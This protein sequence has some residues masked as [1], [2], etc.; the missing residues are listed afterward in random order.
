M[1]GL[2]ILGGR[3]RPETL[4]EY[5]KQVLVVSDGIEARRSVG[6]VP[7]SLAVR[8]P[9]EAVTASENYPPWRRGRT[10][11]GCSTLRS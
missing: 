11:T 7:T 1:T 4:V 6:A 3:P 5:I 2:R 9:G 8:T 10:N